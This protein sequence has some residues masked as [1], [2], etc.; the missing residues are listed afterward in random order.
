MLQSQKMHS[1]HDGFEKT[2]DYTMMN[3][4]TEKMVRLD[5][6]S[7]LHSDTHMQIVDNIVVA[8]KVINEAVKPAEWKA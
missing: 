7:F 2:K 3:C 1:S 4:T 5:D 8:T 6:S